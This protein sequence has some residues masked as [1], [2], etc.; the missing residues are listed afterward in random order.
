[1]S[2]S[3]FATFEPKRRG[4]WFKLLVGF[5]VIALIVAGWLFLE[6]IRG[7]AGLRKYEEELRAKG[8]KLVFAEL[9]P[10]LPDGQNK[11]IELVGLCNS[12]RTGAVLN[13]NAPPAWK[14]IAPGKALVITKESDWINNKGDR[15]TWEQVGKDLERN[16]E[17]LEE[18]RTIVRSP[19]L[20]YPFNYRGVSTLLPHLGRQRGAAQ[21]LSASALYKIHTNDI[22]GAIDDIESILMLA[23]L[24]EHEPF[25]ISQLVRNT[26]VLITVPRCWPLLQHDASDADLMRLQKIFSEADT[27]DPMILGL[28][29]ERAMA[30]DTFALIRSAQINF[31]DLAD[32]TT[33]FGDDDEPSHAL[34]NVPYGDEMKGALRAHVIYPIWRH[35]FSYEDERHAIEEMQRIIDATRAAKAAR[36]AAGLKPLEATF[37]EKDKP[38]GDY[39]SWKYFGTG[40][41]V[42]AN[43]KAG[44]STFRAQTHC[45]M[46]VAAVALKRYHMRHKKFP[47]SLDGLVPEF[48]SEVPIDYM[49]GRPLRYRLDGDQFVLWS[50]GLDGKDDGG[51]PKSEPHFEWMLGPDDVWPQPASEAEATAYRESQPKR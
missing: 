29:G 51:M 4:I 46:F 33:Q 7:Q 30:R 32:T 9:I 23:R 34:A 5:C 47:D 8:E 27:L 40:L 48:V 22:S 42:P 14:S 25:L 49:D 16:R 31:D 44:N 12:F 2:N 15:L 6:R 28:Q 45:K 35:V 10:P 18:L 26:L 1:V 41:L 43:A 21:W 37:K 3:D 11:A 39:R 13:L 24:T 19:A 50:V 38:G 20:R 36:S 17:V